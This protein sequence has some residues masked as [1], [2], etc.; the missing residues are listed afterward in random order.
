VNP[1]APPMK[2]P[3]RKMHAEE[4]SGDAT[5]RLLALRVSRGIADTLMELATLL[6]DIARMPPT[7][8]GKAIPPR[9]QR[10]LPGDRSR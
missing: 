10:I 8:H 5:A 3:R 7:S 6:V 4:R 1:T 9:L 2:S